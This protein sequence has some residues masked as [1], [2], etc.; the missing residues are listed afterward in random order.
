MDTSFQRIVSSI[1]EFSLTETFAPAITFRQL[2][3]RVERELTL[4]FF[5]CRISIELLR[6]LPGVLNSRQNEPLMKPLTG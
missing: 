6:Y 1:F 2:A 3:G 5:R 4:R